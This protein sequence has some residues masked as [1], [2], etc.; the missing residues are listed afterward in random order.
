MKYRYSNPI[1]ETLTLAFGPDGQLSMANLDGKD[2]TRTFRYLREE[3]HA[4][5][6]RPLGFRND[7]TSEERAV[8][9]E[10]N[11]RLR[12]SDLFV[13]NVEAVD[14]DWILSMSRDDPKMESATHKV[15]NLKLRIN[16]NDWTTRRIESM[17]QYALGEKIRSFLTG[18][19]W[20]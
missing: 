19:K 11:K 12:G 16:G 13:V 10:A 18:A 15:V 7:V 3:R 14:G 1:D 5:V 4:E 8:A 6:L 9:V 2:V 17:Y 20:H